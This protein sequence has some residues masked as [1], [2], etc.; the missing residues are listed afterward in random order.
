MRH[1]LFIALLLPALAP[2]QALPPALDAADLDAYARKVLADWHAPG[3]ALAV[4]RDDKV[5]LLR[6]YGDRE[7]GKPDP[8]DEH[9]I[10][11]IASCTKAFTAA[12]LAILVDEGKVRWDD[13][14]TKF[15]PGFQL[16]DP[17]VTREL[18]VR[19]LLCHRSGLATFAGDLV[20]YNTAYDRAEVLR[21]ARF[22]KP[23]SSF[24]SAFGYQNILFLAAGQVVPAAAGKSWDEFV[25]ERIFTPLGMATAVTSSR[26]ISAGANA[27]TPH[28]VKAGKPVAL[29]RYNSDNVGPA[30]AIHA[31]ADDLARWVR[32]QLGRGK[33]EDKRVYSEARAREMWSPQTPLG[34][35]GDPGKASPA[36]LRAYAL[37]W[38]VSD[39]HGRLRV[40]HD[41]SID[42]MFSKIV[43]L[44]ELKAGVVALTNSDTGAADALANRAVDQ[45]VGA[46][47]RDRSGEAA[48]RHKAGEAA[49]AAAR[50]RADAA[51]AKDSKPSLPLDRYAGKYGGDLYGDVAVALEDGKLV[52]RF[53]PAAS[54][55]AD[56]EHWQFDTFRVKWRTLKPYIPDGWATFVLDRRGRPAEVRVDCPNPDFDFT[57][58]ELKRR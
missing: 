46:P 20:W 51:R 39:Y 28:T 13:K 21:R 50:Q 31:S 9:T 37:G 32:L 36:H 58:L 30:A 16:S 24:R 48:A 14:A 53:A 4:V 5:V 10:F 25:Q 12:A 8:V 23:V 54:F 19:D 6:G 41:G 3:V 7:A 27:A 57:E 18:T 22:L 11:A 44:P 45:L 55:V 52:L 33:F 35:A 49:R 26:A 43:L 38:F 56:L 2:A 42:G 17:Y 1:S 15:L 47:P 29:S 34:L 40:E